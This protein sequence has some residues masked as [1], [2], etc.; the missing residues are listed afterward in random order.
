MPVCP[1]LLNF[2]F[3]LKETNV[4]DA[5]ADSD[6]KRLQETL[7]SSF[8]SATEQDM[9]FGGRPVGLH[10]PTPGPAASAA[11]PA[12][13]SAAAAFLGSIGGRFASGGTF[14]PEAA[15]GLQ[16]GVTA[17]AASAQQAQHDLPYTH[18]NT[19]ITS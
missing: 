7:A 19:C 12:P 4:Y 2:G 5:A 14:E 8:S 15:G 13:S 10:Q 16:P 6:R 1:L 18:V 9:G 11:A 17:A 3:G